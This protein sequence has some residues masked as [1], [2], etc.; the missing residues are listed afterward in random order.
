MDGTDQVRD[1]LQEGQTSEPET[2]ET[3]EEPTFTIEQINE[4]VEKRVSDK[5]A[6]SGRDWQT[7]TSENESLKGNLESLKSEI[8]ALQGEIKE[9]S[10]DNTD[11]IDVT[12][13]RAEIRDRERKVR[14]AEGKLEKNWLEQ[15]EK[16]Q[17][18]DKKERDL[19][20]LK[21]AKDKEIN[22]GQLVKLLGEDPSEQRINEV[23]GIL[24]AAKPKKE[25]KPD[26]LKSA[27]S[28]E[29]SSEESLKERYPK[30][31]GG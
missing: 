14:E 26:P 15:V 28:S 10:A 17:A 22:L 12:K 4:M 27:G 9:L 13:L 1:S 30:M 20:I 6:T 3:S 25:I 23:A 16:V 2:Q 31:Y 8:E 7:V 19:L 24:A 21:A 29:K 5:L 18:A 11:V